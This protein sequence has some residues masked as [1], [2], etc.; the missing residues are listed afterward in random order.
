[1]AGHYRLSDLFLPRLPQ[2][3]AYWLHEFSK[4]IS[5]N[6]DIGDLQFR[7][8]EISNFFPLH[9]A[10]KPYTGLNST[11]TGLQAIKYRRGRLE[12]L[13]QLKLPH[14]FVYDDVSTCED[15]FDCIKSMRVR[16]TMLE[17]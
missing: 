9:L 4:V 5:T 15:A 13:D 3:P 8:R 11:M 17:S 12:V 2:W 10:R 6:P 7:S 1:M 16:G 14:E